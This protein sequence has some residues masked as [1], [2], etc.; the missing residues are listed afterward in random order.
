MPPFI[1][2]HAGTNREAGVDQGAAAP[3][4]YELLNIIESDSVIISVNE[5]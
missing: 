3:G 2:F 1:L 4:L 5:L